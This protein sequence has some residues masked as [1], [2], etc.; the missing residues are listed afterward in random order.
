M[1]KALEELPALARGVATRDGKIVNEP[2]AAAYY[3]G[4]RE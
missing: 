3:A 1:E 4:T 2:L